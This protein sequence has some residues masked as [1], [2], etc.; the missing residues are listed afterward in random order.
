MD[1]WG[2]IPASCVH[3]PTLNI[4]NSE[5]AL[6]FIDKETTTS[7]QKQEADSAGAGG[8]AAAPCKVCGDKASGYHYGV[9]SCEGCKGFFRRSIQKQ[10]EYRCL[11]DGKCL[12]IRLNRN[13]CQFCRFKKCLAVGMSRDSV[14]YGR[15]PKRPRE[16]VSSESMPD[17]TKNLGVGTPTPTSSVEE[18]DTDSLQLELARDLAKVVITAHRNN[19]AYSEDYVRSMHLKAIIVKTE[20]ADNDG[21]GGE[22]AACSGAVRA[23]KLTALWYNVAVRMTP[24]V[25]QVVEFAKRVPGFNVL[26]QDD[27]LILIK[28]GFFEVWLSR[29][30]RISSEATI[31]FDDGNSID[32]TQLEL[33]YDIPFAKSMLAYTA[34]INK[35]CI[36]EDEMAL[37][38]A[39][40]LLSPHRNGLSD[41]DKITA[42]HMSLM[43]AFQFVVTES[44]ISD[45]PA[46]MEAFAVATRE[47]RVLGLQHND[48]LTWCRLNWQRLVLP[49][50]F[51]EIFDIPKGEEEDPEASA[52]PSPP[53]CSVPQQG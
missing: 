6:T 35:M 31:L 49:A 37:F 27:Q 34:R 29:M 44:G 24:T 10:I 47:A 13:R 5:F 46:R 40:L 12:V 42:L 7:Q 26:P 43:E 50:L 30:G 21:N 52:L 25:Q 15:V 45:V 19:D 2:G 38:S 28:L 17:L 11:R 41:K 48:Q 33:M 18:M 23:N 9:T 36:T 8:K 1:V 39:T 51:S 14:R 4:E 20:D 32:Q 22:E 3:A 16:V 53:S